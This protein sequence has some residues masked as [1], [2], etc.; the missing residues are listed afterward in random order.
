MQSCPVNDEIKSIFKQGEWKEYTTVKKEKDID[1]NENE[2]LTEK[3]EK[4][5]TKE[6]LEEKDEDIF[7][8]DEQNVELQDL[9]CPPIISDKFI[10]DFPTEGFNN[11]T[12]EQEDGIDTID[13]NKMTKITT[14]QEANKLTPPTFI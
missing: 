5:S 7:P 10:P 11:N 8:I 14:I 9:H 3:E 6:L 4:D 2:I 1:N 13:L 12:L